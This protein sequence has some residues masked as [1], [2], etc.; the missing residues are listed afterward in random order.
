MITYY[1]RNLKDKKLK[2]LDAF[3]TGCW[4]NVVNPTEEEIEFLTEKFDLDKQN[5]ISGL[6]K[7]EV[8]RVEFD[9]GN[10]YILVKLISTSKQLLSTCLILLTD[11]FIL[12]LSA[13]EPE[14]VRKIFEKKIKLVTA[15]KLKVL[16][17]F[18]DTI[19]DEFERATI[20]IVKII[21][22]K[23]SASEEMK[24]NDL[25]ILLQQ[26]EKLNSFIS[27]YSYATLIYGRLIK[28]IR[29]FE[30]DKE[31]MEDLIIDSN[32]GLNMCKSSLKT[33]SNLRGY[34]TIM[35]SNKMNRTITMLTIFMAF[36][37]IS[38]TITGFYGMNVSLPFQNNSLVFLYIIISI[39]MVGVL[40][41][42]YFLKSKL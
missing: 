12:T 14:F 23:K 7:N 41:I 34:H 30:E 18:L 20:N 37:G 21:N 2:R 36:L 35:L 6:D 39:L 31:I 22:A 28:K 9:E 15:Q 27:A 25:N 32:Q 24:E 8:P 38:T 10:T 11:K 3:Q 16:I 29:F 19:D 26:E 13:E 4:I 42:V 5:L 1:K 17:K 40:L 33:I